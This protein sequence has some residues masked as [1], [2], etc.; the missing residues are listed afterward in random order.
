MLP[1]LKAVI[2]KVMLE[3]DI[4]LYPPGMSTLCIMLYPISG[5]SSR[6][7]IP[8]FEKKKKKKTVKY[9]SDWCE[10]LM[11]VAVTMVVMYIEDN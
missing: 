6:D 2:S 1:G 7:V 8:I 4:I 10:W 9:G 11:N 3:Y 5:F